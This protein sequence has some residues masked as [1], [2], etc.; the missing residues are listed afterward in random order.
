MFLSPSE[1]FYHYSMTV[2]YRAIKI[3]P[4]IENDL[5]RDSVNEAQFPH[6]CHEES[7]AQNHRR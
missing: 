1:C 2:S 5:S 4:F 3:V 7:L 6:N